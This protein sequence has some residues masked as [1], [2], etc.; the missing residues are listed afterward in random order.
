MFFGLLEVGLKL[1]GFGRSTAFFVPDSQRGV[2]RTNPRFTELFLPASF[3]LKPVDFRLTRTKPPGTCRIFVVGESAA[4]GVPEPAF[5]LAPQL[6]AQL[7]ATLPGTQVDVYNL[8]VTAINSHAIL[9]IVRQALEFEPDV[10]VVYMGNNEVVGPY[11]PSSVVTGG[12][13]PSWLIRGALWV[14]AT[15]TGQ[16][17]QWFAGTLQR[18]AFKDWRGMEM[19]AGKAVPADDPRLAGVYANFAANLDEILTL[20][21]RRQVEVVLSTVATNVRD[22]APF[23]SRHD[24]R[25][26]A[27]Q[28]AAWSREIEPAERAS[29]LGQEREAREHLARAAEID[30]LHADSQFRLAQVLDAAGEHES[31]RPH[32]LIAQQEDALRFRADARINEIIRQ[33]AAS[34]PGPVSLVD[35]AREFGSDLPS[36]ARPSG[37]EFFFEH[38]HLRWEGNFALGRLLAPCVRAALAGGETAAA[39]VSWLDRGACARAL[40][41]TEFGRLAMAQ[42]M[43]VLTSRPPFTGQ[44]TYAKDRTRLLEEIAANEARLAAPPAVAAAVASVDEAVRHDPTNPSL[45]F[46]A[47]AV[48]LQAGHWARA[49]ALNEQADA[50]TPF[51]PEILAQKGYLLSRLGRWREAEAAL[52]AAAEDAPFYFQTYGLLAS[53]WMAAGRSGEAKAYFGGLVARMPESRAARSIY[54]GLLAHGGDVPGAEMQWRAVLAQVPDDESALAP[55]IETLERGGAH[56]EALALV[57]AAFAYNPRSFENNARLVAAFE[58]RNDPARL[59]TYLQALA[60]SGP[61]NAQLHLDLAR[62]LEALGRTEDARVARAIASRLAAIERDRE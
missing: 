53:V 34:A 42:G 47:A 35:A 37:A 60:A 44:S 30:P 6:Q 61:V 46:Q 45:L 18:T 29:A 59:V 17:F 55:L 41:F 16:L 22:C 48:H 26:G 7:R 36:S 40:G 13:P 52:L 24:P 15:R 8:A 19:F 31:A 23:L 1:G 10:L 54:A 49:L 50:A 4:M 3:G 43:S 11:G 20:A 2:F 21:H 39:G 28:R 32:F 12:V 57:Q 25:L 58:E 56:S 51:S 62:H 9:P 33:A 5:G 38:V 14:R 27:E